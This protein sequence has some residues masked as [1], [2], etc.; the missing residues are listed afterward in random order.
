MWLLEKGGGVVGEVAGCVGSFSL[1]GL[2]LGLRSG[3]QNVYCEGVGVSVSVA[4]AGGVVEVRV[5]VAVEARACWLRLEGI[6]SGRKRIFHP[7]KHK[8][9]CIYIYALLIAPDVIKVLK[10]SKV[11]K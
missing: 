1:A 9:K 4:G 7:V 11:L 2:G 10:K 3:V 8:Q 6:R 5:D